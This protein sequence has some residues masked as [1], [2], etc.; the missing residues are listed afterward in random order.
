MKA[1][2]LLLAALCGAAARAG[3]F[4]LE[5]TVDLM[6]RHNLLAAGA[7]RVTPRPGQF[8]DSVS[9]V[10]NRG[11]WTGTATVRT[12]NFFQQVPDR[13]LDR[14]D[15]SLY[16]RALRYDAG[17]WTLQL[18]DFN[19]ILG[20]GMLLSVIRNP[21][22][23]QEDT[24]DGGDATGRFGR[25]E[26]HALDGSVTTEKGDQSWRVA[27]VEASLA[28][29]EGHRVAL[30]AAGI[31]DGRR[32]AFGPPPVG[33][34]QCR[35]VGVAGR[36]R[37]GTLSYAAEWGQVAFR[38]RKPP[39]VPVA[40]DP[41]E[42][43]GAYGNLTWQRGAWLLMGEYKRYE[44]F[45]NALNSPPLADRETEKN[46][47]RDASGRRLFVQRSFR[48][49]DLTVFL[50]AGRY[51]EGTQSG[52]NIYGGFKLQDGFGRLDL[53]CTYGLRTVAL[54]EKRTEAGLTW[55]FTPRWSLD[56]TLR[57]QRNRP[58]G[59]DPYQAT[60]LTVQVAWSPRLAVFLLQ[61]RS[62]VPVF[63]STRL[64]H[65]GLRVNLAKGSY[66]ELSGGR[67][68]G[69]EVCAGGQCIKLPPFKGW[70]LAAHLRI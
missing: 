11:P 59:S 17:H 43:T 33:L 45:D 23:L 60:D 57:D 8:Q 44:N 42:G 69:G 2:T 31:Q 68:R 6:Q 66:L 46:N 28:F 21:A 3:D 70:Q 63:A 18:G 62:S 49:P 53:T 48:E 38:D 10:G 67:L 19:T 15:T 55:R 51:R 64:Y 61:Q 65:G 13:T 7:D 40:V 54:P 27:G 37:S 50:S 30:R 12:V 39:S 56:L 14:A 22:L 25:L 1:R 4:T 58:P 52:Q 36:D 9:F 35:S 32:P 34:R 47:L 24:L 26:V 16:K 41:R 20:R 5:G 29:L